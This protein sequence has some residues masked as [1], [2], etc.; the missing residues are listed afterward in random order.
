MKP[1]YHILIADACKDGIENV[2]LVLLRV[3]LVQRH[4]ADVITSGLGENS[5]AAVNSS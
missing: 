5:I 1:E 4:E 2:N 3:K